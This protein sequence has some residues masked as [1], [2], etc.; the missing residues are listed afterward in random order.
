MTDNQFSLRAA[1]IATAFVAVASL[2]AKY[3]VAGPERALL[4]RGPVLIGAA[5]GTLAGRVRTGIN[6][7]FAFDIFAMGVALLG[8]MFLRG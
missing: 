1:F 6:V 5:I 2:A 7:G 4:A 8:L 3:A